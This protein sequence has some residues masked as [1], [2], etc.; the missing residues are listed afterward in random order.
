MAAE[1][2]CF[3]PA[4]NGRKE[5]VRLKKMTDQMVV[6]QPPGKV[7]APGTV[8][9]AQVGLAAVECRGKNLFRQAAEALCKI[10]LYQAISGAQSKVGILFHGRLAIEIFQQ[11]GRIT[12]AGKFR[13]ITGQVAR[14]QPAFPQPVS[15]KLWAPQPTAKQ[16]RRF[17]YARLWAQRRPGRAKLE[18]S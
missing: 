10:I 2:R 9:V 15:K 3:W 4:G 8:Q 17:Q 1:K 12:A 14:D 13:P 6:D 5:K 18:I 7:K 11:S 16:E